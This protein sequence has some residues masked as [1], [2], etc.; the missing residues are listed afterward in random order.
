V[1]EGNTTKGQQS[2]ALGHLD[3]MTCLL[4]IE[5]QLDRVRGL[6]V[7]THTQE[8]AQCR[9]LLRALERE[10][11]L[12]TRALFEED[13]PLPSRLAQFQERARKSMQWVWGLIVGLAAT[14]VYA[15]YSSFV[16]PWQQQLEQ[17]GF[18]GTNLLGLLIFQGAFWK[19][20]QSMVTLLE[21][22]ALAT[23]AG[24]AMIVL[25]RRNRRGYVAAMLL[26]ALGSGVLLASPA[27]AT[28]FRKGETVE[29]VRADEVIHGDIYI[30]GERARVEGT[31][32]GDV[33]IFAQSAEVTGHVKGDVITFARSTRISGQVDGNVRA[34]NNSL[35]ISG[36]VEKNVLTFAESMELDADGKVGGSVTGFLSVPSLDGQIG[37]DVL[38]MDHS[39]SINGKVKG[40]VT[41]RGE[42][43]TIGPKAEIDGHTKFEG[44]KEA[45]VSSQAKLAYPVEFKKHEHEAQNTLS[46]YIWQVIWTAALILFGLVVFLLLPDFSRQSMANAERYGASAGLG[47]LVLFGVPIAAIIACITVVGLFIGLSTLF[48]WYAALYVAQVIIGGLVGQWLLG[49]TSELWPL[50]GRM[51]LGLLLVRFVTAVP[52]IGGWVK[53]AVVLW[54]MGAISLS[55]YRRFA[56]VVAP[57]SGSV[58]APYA[59]PPL[60]PNTTVGGIQP[61]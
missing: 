28:E 10:S 24:F 55:I 9:T 47:V 16:A 44:N 48:L 53:F 42:T 34:F 33:F 18:G 6:E 36:K 11:R 20:W 54:G 50:I 13:E 12:L 52:E 23:L 49:R 39:T 59:P 57:P 35:T 45:E 51:V 37:G 31:V 56:P 7:S 4:F 1:S 5:R 21:V 17:A 15:L 41:V 22:L 58:P 26:A 30:T 8:C 2:G 43:F 25:R 14:G 46:H 40:S 3:E 61:A 38:L 27:S 29:T 19:G 32:E 60:P